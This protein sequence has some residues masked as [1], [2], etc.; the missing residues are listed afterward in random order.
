MV[1]L[2]AK[3]VSQSQLVAHQTTR[4]C[5]LT[6]R[7]F[8]L[9]L[10]PGQLGRLVPSDRVNDTEEAAERKALCRVLKTLTWVTLSPART[11][12]G[13]LSCNRRDRELGRTLIIGTLL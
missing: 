1:A 2:M 6:M 7:Y 9:K 10:F 8:R 12:E 13:R 11:I 3:F 4:D 5:R